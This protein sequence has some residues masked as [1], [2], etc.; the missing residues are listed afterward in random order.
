LLLDPVPQIEAPVSGVEVNGTVSISEDESPIRG[1]E[2]EGTY[3]DKIEVLLNENPDLNGRQIAE[4]VG[5]SERTA[6]K[7]KNRIQ[8]ITPLE[9]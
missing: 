2:F 7:W 8:I 1:S 3:G 6:R 5:C 9:D 4:T